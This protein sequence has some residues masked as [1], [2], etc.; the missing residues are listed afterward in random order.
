[1]FKNML[2]PQKLIKFST[3]RATFSTS[4]KNLV[5]FKDGVYNN[6]PFKVHN[7]KIPFAV[8][9][10]GFFG[11]GFLVPFITCYVQMK[12]SGTL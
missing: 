9:H 12:K 5:H 2:R 7:R 1:M 4:S 6:I 10:F 11:V 3:R 8:V